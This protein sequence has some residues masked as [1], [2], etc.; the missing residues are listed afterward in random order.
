MTPVPEI[1]PV[2]YDPGFLNHAVLCESDMTNDSIY[3]FA[4]IVDSIA[5]FA[6]ATCAAWLFFWRPVSPRSATVERSSTVE[7]RR[8]LRRYSWTPLAALVVVLG[9]SISVQAGSASSYWGS[10]VA[11]LLSLATLGCVGWL[12]VRALRHR[13]VI[14]LI[15]N[16]DDATVA[17]VD[18]NLPS[19]LLVRRESD[20]SDHESGAG[21][22][23]I[24][25]FNRRGLGAFRGLES[26]RLYG[27]QK[28]GSPT[29]V[30]GGSDHLIIG[31]AT[32]RP[33][34]H[35]HSR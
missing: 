2:C 32:F 30:V 9:C 23:R 16:G 28:S 1:Y 12:V 8:I 31:W 29:V 27:A 18:R 10:I 11:P 7:I 26:V 24:G 22:V 15:V 6:L 14:D 34:Q 17:T 20:D 21:Q 35:P 3:R 19:G 4:A 5:M 13:L 33:N 25:A